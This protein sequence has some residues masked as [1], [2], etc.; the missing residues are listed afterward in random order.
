LERR[1]TIF[2][3]EHAWK[4]PQKTAL[5]L[6]FFE[7]TRGKIVS[8]DLFSLRVLCGILAHLVTPTFL[9]AIQQCA[10]SQ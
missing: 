9:T 5:P 8:P 10:S 7:L 2:T 1:I 3:A 4:P 6:L